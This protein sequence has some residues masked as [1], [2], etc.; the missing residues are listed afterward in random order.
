MLDEKTEEKA[1]SHRRPR[2]ESAQLSE[3]RLTFLHGW[4]VSG[5]AALR[6]LRTGGRSGRLP[7]SLVH[8]ARLDHPSH[9]ALGFGRAVLRRDEPK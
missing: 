3:A 8:L 2:H 6:A 1:K 7:H 4:I 9:L 5:R